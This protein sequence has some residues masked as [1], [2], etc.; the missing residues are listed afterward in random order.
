VP[1]PF[2]G[3]LPGTS[4]NG[5]TVQQQQLLVPYPEF[6]IN[7]VTE[8]FEPIGKSSYN[9]VQVVAAKRMSFGLNF[10]VSYTISK[11][12]DQTGFANPQDVNLERVIAAWDIPQ[13]LQINFLYELPFRYDKPLGGSL[14]RPARWAI[15]GWQLSTLVRL[16]EGMPMNFPAGAAPT[17][18]NPTLSDASYTEWFNTCTLLASGAT[19]NCHSGEQPAWTIRQPNTLQMWSSRL[20]SVRLPGVHNVDISMIKRNRLTERFNLIFRTDFINGF[21]SPQF[22]SGPVTTVTSGNFGRI[23]GAMDQS[24]LPRFIQ[25][26]MKL[27]F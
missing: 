26:S 18:V 13:N 16:Q 8:A 19:Q 2:A 6:L 4:L 25:L 10:N 22:F 20:A 9:S 7:G 17:G 21:N 24:N 27:Q 11:Q 3:H 15:S 23:S 1:N 5:A 14:P 12:I